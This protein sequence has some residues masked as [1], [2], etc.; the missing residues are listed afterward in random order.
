MPLFAKQRRMGREGKDEVNMALLG[1]R[2]ETE[3]S[4]TGK[5]NS[6][7]KMFSWNGLDIRKNMGGDLQSTPRTGRLGGGWLNSNLDKSLASKTVYS[8]RRFW[9]LR[10]SP[11]GVT[12]HS[13]VPHVLPVTAMRD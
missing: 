9:S 13:M 7:K 2:V 11:G 1:R 5:E 12:P 4:N 6:H 10:Q 3:A 8:T